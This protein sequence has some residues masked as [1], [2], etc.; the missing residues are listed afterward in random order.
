MI[1]EEY[2]ENKNKLIE[3]VAGC[4]K[5]LDMAIDKHETHIKN[6]TTATPES[7]EEMMGFM[8][9]ARNCTISRLRKFQK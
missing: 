4:M 3:E 9:G 6:P 2:M 1:Q 5:L 8:L 7:Q